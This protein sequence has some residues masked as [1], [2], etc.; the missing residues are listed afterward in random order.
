MRL[1]QEKD[2]RMQLSIGYQSRLKTAPTEYILNRSL[3]IPSRR[4]ERTNILGGV[5]E[6]HIL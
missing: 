4:Q 2:E 3:D 5:D 6:P 1:L